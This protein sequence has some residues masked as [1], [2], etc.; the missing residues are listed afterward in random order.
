MVTGRR[1]H[2]LD[3]GKISPKIGPT[4][5]LI[6]WWIVMPFVKLSFLM[7]ANGPTGEIRNASE[8]AIVLSSDV[9]RRARLQIAIA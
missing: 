9:V 5:N 3:R 1:N 7:S 4:R 2:G 6:E 8:L